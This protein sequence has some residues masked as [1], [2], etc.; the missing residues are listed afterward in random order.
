M[1]IEPDHACGVATATAN[2]PD[3]WIAVSEEHERKP[4]V[5]PGNPNGLR[6]DPAELERAADLGRE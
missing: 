1:R 2:T 5:I 6:D 3:R 4:A